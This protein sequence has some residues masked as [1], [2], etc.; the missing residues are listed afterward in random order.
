MASRTELVYNSSISLDF[1]ETF[2]YRHSRDVFNRLR[3]SRILEE[4]RRMASRRIP[5]YVSD[6]D[7]LMMQYFDNGRRRRFIAFELKNMR[8]DV[9]LIGRHVK[10]NG[11]QYEL[12]YYFSRM[13]GIDFYYLVRV[14]KEYFLWNIA[15]APVK[16]EWLGSRERGTYDYY[17]LVPKDYVAQIPEDE[18]PR[19][20]RDLIFEG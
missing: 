13:A 10:V 3:L 2:T 1:V 7:S 4:A 16:F 19:Y 6:V 17:A 15:R 11:K 8:P 18:L 12:H 9:A 20:L 5:V 14:G